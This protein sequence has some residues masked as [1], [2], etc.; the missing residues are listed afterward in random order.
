MQHCPQANVLRILCRYLSA[1]ALLSVCFISLGCIGVCQNPS[2]K[3]LPPQE[4]SRPGSQ[5]I[6]FLWSASSL[7]SELQKFLRP[8]YLQGT[9]PSCD[10]SPESFGLASWWVVS[11]LLAP[12]RPWWTR[13]VQSRHIPGFS[14]LESILSSLLISPPSP[15]KFLVGVWLFS[16]SILGALI[17]AYAELSWEE[18][19]APGCDVRAPVCPHAQPTVS[20][21]NNLPLLNI[22]KDSFWT[23]LP[24]CLPK[25]PRLAENEM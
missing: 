16:W 11:V 4:K 13:K 19:T 7:S 21:T 2:I 5:L 23:L 18:V 20:I 15:V 24:L 1:G 22:R 12:M 3:H 14:C 6:Y 25:L 9:S 10:L 8:E 17:F